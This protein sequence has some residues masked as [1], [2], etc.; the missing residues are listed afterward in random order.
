MEKKC[1]IVNLEGSS[2]FVKQVAE[3][4]SVKIELKQEIKI[5][6]I[7]ESD[8][9]LKMEPDINPLGINPN[10]FKL[11]INRSQ[12][13][14]ENQKYEQK[15]NRLTKIQMPLDLQYGNVRYSCDQCD[16]KATQKGDLKKHIDSVHGDVWYPCDQCDHKA[17]Q[18]GNLKTHKDSLHG[19]VWHSCDQ[20]DYK[21]KWK[22]NLKKHIDSGHW[23]ICDQ[24]GNSLCLHF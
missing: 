1:N 14:N 5:E 21:T 18:K 20:C 4:V 7:N 3:V 23:Y 8:P 2:L 19:D 17:R 13:E 9:Q 12:A 11:S 15:K 22:D 16:H 10:C 24:C 6:P